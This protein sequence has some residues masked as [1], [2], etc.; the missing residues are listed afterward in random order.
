MKKVLLIRLDKIGDLVSTMC[1]DE[2][3]CLSQTEVRWVI[4]KGLGF[5]PNCA[6]PPRTYVELSKDDWKS[7]L[8]TL[9]E[10]I[11]TFKPDVAVSF[12]APWWVNFALWIE[13]V[14]VRSGVL[15]QWH[16]F[17]FLNRGLRQRRSKAIKHEAD[18]N[19]DVL[20]YAMGDSSS[21]PTPV[22]KLVAPSNP[23]LL[24][25]HHLAPKNYVVVHPGMAGSALNWPIPRYIELIEKVAPQIQVVLTG[26]PADEPWLTEIK[27]TFK[28]N[29]KVL[30]LQSQLTA[31]ELFTVLKNAK[32]V[33]VPSTGVAHMAASLGAPVLGLYS[34]LRVQHP[35]RWAARGPQVHIFVPK[36]ESEN[37][38][39]EITVQDLLN[40][41]STL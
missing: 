23:E 19:M 28:N 25:K 22:L 5:I 10:Y 21:E 17:L 40:K 39:E 12:Q 9:R 6:Q 37:C 34:P 3:S 24:A 13:K 16:S 14:P 30:N 38:M 4:S 2:A 31:P 7:S 29:S 15:S 20:K 35:T 11:H 8:R 26:T 27:E 36:A 33:V 18:Y 41:L 32:A 1:V